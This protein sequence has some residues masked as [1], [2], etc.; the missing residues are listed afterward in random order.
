VIVVTGAAPNSGAVTP[1]IPSRLT[2]AAVTGNTAVTTPLFEL[3]L[4]LVAPAT[5]KLF[6]IISISVNPALA[7]R[8]MVAVYAVSAAK[9]PLTSGLQLITPVYWAVSAIVDTGAAPNSGAV[10]PGMANMS[11]VASVTGN[12]AVTSPLSA[13]LPTDVAPATVKLSSTTPLRVNP[14]LGVRVMV[15]VY[16]VSAAKVPLTSG[17]Q[18][19]VPVY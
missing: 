7:V 16:A 1:G 15:A 11:T 3:W 12:S 8:E 10:T 13:L 2:V 19:T 17:L 9:V 14:V 18:L 5:V 4:T 6:S